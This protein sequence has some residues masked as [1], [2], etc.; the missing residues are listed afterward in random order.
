MKLVARP[1]IIL[2]WYLHFLIQTLFIIIVKLYKELRKFKS[3]RQV[4]LTTNREND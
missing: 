4:G 1:G 3:W 2:I